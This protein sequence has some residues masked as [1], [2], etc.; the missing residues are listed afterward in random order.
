MRKIVFSAVVILLAGACWVVAQS[1]SSNRWASPYAPLSA[2]APK[3]TTESDKVAPT[4]VPPPDVQTI[5]PTTDLD[6]PAIPSAPPAPATTSSEK[7]EAPVFT[8]PPND[9]ELQPPV[10]VPS[11][12][13]ILQPAVPDRQPVRAVTV[14][15]VPGLPPLPPVPGTQSMPTGVPSYVGPA[16]TGNGQTIIPN[17]MQPAQNGDGVHET[18][19]WTVD[20]PGNWDGAPRIDAAERAR[21]ADRVL[22]PRIWASADYLLWF[23]KAAHAPSL[24][25][26]VTGTQ[27]SNSMFRP[28]QVTDLFPASSIDFNPLAGIRGT[29]GFWL[30]PSQTV[31]LEASYFWFGPSHLRDDFTSS[32]DSILGRPFF[33]LGTGSNSLFPVSSLNGTDGFITV[34]NSFHAE[35]GDANLLLNSSTFGSSLNLLAGFRYLEIDERLRVD[36]FSLNNSTGFQINAFDSFTTRNQFFGGQLGLKWNYQGDRIVAGISGKVALGTMEETVRINGA[37]SIQATGMA[38]IQTSG[39]VLALN[40]NI[41]TQR[42]SRLAYI[43]ELTANLGYRLTP[44]ATVFAGYNFM[45]VSDMVRPG[46]QIDATVNP[47]NFPFGSAGTIANHPGFQFKNE[48]FWMQGINFG[49]ALQY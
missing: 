5:A 13:P 29:V 46:R 48:D 16:A 39:G 6:L 35:G 33:N 40:T 26:S 28:A 10:V 8:S 11:E 14:P 18:P 3:T 9:Q 30:N 27:S 24:V 4:I 23:I 49:V 25:Q 1:A 38:P 7:I 44:W 37:T 45:Y 34:R 19:R 12:N 47:Q 15:A 36:D 32:S 41:G 43:P 31:G 42:R 20:G 17:R 21:C 2:P 22:G